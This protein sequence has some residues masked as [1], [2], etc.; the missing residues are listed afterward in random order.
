MAASGRVAGASGA[1]GRVPRAVGCGCGLSLGL[2]GFRYG[3]LLGLADSV[4]KDPG[5]AASREL[6]LSFP[7]SYFG[8]E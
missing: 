8:P 2:T 6:A 7:G 4:A 3:L 5:D 1:V